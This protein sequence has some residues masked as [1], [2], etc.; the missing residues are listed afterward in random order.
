MCIYKRLLYDGC[1]H[2]MWAPVPV[3]LCAGAREHAEGLEPAEPCP[4][5]R[6]HPL[7]TVRVG[8][9]CGR[10]AD[11][12]AR[13]GRARALLSEGRRTLLRADERCRAILEDAGVDVPSDAEG[14]VVPE[15]EEEEVEE[16]GGDESGE[17]AEQTQVETQAA[18]FLKRRKE[19]DKAGL[20][21]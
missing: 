20:F 9:V 21:M 4:G 10:C 2:T 6:G 5:P 8:G 12:D 15:E 18:E 11:T 1:K 16:Q 13:L 17:G 3:R 19:G 7:A 14:E